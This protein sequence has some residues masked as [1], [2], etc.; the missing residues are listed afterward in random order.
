MKRILLFFVG[1]FFCLSG[2]AQVAEQ[3]P[4]N[5]TA[6]PDTINL[7]SVKT[8]KITRYA[9]G[10]TVD[11]YDFFKTVVPADGTIR[12][13]VTV[14]NISKDNGNP[15]ATAGPDLNFYL[16][17]GTSYKFKTVQNGSP[18]PYG[19]SATDT[20]V[21]YARAADTAFI[22]I[23]LPGGAIREYT[24]SLK[25]ELTDQAPNDAEPNHSMAQALPVLPAEMKA[26]HSGYYG[27]ST[28]SQGGY[29]GGSFDEYDY[30]RIILPTA[31]S[32]RFYLSAYNSSGVTMSTP[33][34]TVLNKNGTSRGIISTNGSWS[35]GPL[36]IGTNESIAYKATVYDTINSYAS[37]AD[38]LYFSI[39]TPG[40]RYSDKCYN[41][42]VKYE[43]LDAGT[44]D[45]EPN[46]NQATATPIA[47][48]ET[49]EGTS[50]YD[51]N[52]DVDLNDYYK[53]LLPADGT[54]RIYAKAIN[55]SGTP[56]AAPVI[57]VTDKNGN[58]L[59]IMN[60]KRNWSN[61]GLTIGGGSDN[62]N[63]G[64]SISDTMSVYSLEADSIYIIVSTPGLRY[65]NKTFNYSF[66][67]EL[68]DQSQ[69][70]TEPNNTLATATMTTAGSIL[71]GHVSYAKVNYQRDVAD[72]YKTVM[73]TNGRIRF[74]VSAKNTN[75]WYDETTPPYLTIYN[76]NGQNIGIQSTS[77]SW[78][79]SAIQIDNAHGNAFYLETVYD[80]LF[81]NCL[82]GDTLYFSIHQTYASFS[83]TIRYE[84]ENNEPSSEFS[85]T[86]TG[87]E[88]GF[89]NQSTNAQQYKWLLGNNNESTVTH[90]FKAYV[91]GYYEVKLISTNT[92]C[93]FKDTVMHPLEI[94]GVEY[95]TP[96][97]AG[98][99]GDLN[100]QIFGG[101]LNP[102]TTLVTLKKGNI[103][104]IPK[105]TYS[106]DKNNRLGLIFDLHNVETGSY[107]VTI[108]VPGQ[109]AITYPGG[110][111]IN[112]LVYP[113][114]WSQVSGPGRWRTNTDT[115]FN[116]VVGNSGN[117]TAHGTIVALLWP[118]SVDLKFEQKEYR[119]STAGTSQVT[120]NDGTYSILNSALDWVYD[121]NTTTPIDT[122]IN[123]AFNGYARYFFV[124]GVEPNSTY[125]IPF[126]VKAGSVANQRFITYTLKPNQFG[127]CP[128]FNI[129]DALTSP[130]AIEFYINEL[131]AAV[132][133]T[134]IVPAKVIVKGLGIS[135]KHIDVSSQIMFHRFWANWY[136]ADDLTE[137]EYYDYYKKEEV[138]NEFAWQK[139]KETAVDLAINRAI[140]SRKADL[141]GDIARYNNNLNNPKIR[142]EMF[143][144]GNGKG[145]VK[146]NGLRDARIDEVLELAKYEKALE[147]VRNVKKID[148]YRKLLE[149]YIKNN[150][151]EHEKQEDYLRDKLNK[152]KDIIDP[153]ET[154]TNSV[155]S[156]DPNAIYGPSGTGANQY[157]NDKNRHPFLITFE[158]AD[159]ASA[160]A[161]IVRIIDTLD[162][163]K[164]DLKTLELGNV[165]IGKK[166]FLVPKGRRE[167][168]ME[169]SLMPEKNMN[170]RINASLDTTKGIITWQF[171]SIDPI[172]KDI[173]ALAGFLPPNTNRPN[174]EGSVSY[175]IQPIANLA[176]GNSMQS[177][178]AIV[179][180]DNTPIITNTWK[181]ILDAQK[182][183]SKA[184]ATVLQDTLI[185]LKM[186][187][188]DL[189]S[190]IGYYNVY[191]SIQDGQWQSLGGTELDTMTVIG[192]PGKTYRFYAVA[193]DKVGNL[194]SKTPAA[195]ASVTLKEGTT[196]PVEP[197]VTSIDS[198]PL[199][200]Y[201]SPTTGAVTVKVK[202]AV[203]EQ[204]V[205]SVYSTTGSKVADVYTGT[206]NGNLNIPVNLSHL[207]NGLY[208]IR[209]RSNAGTQYVQKVMIMK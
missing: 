161:Q 114:T 85:Y 131:D 74:Y 52:F 128:T 105:E 175:T 12:V 148:D 129:M 137:S 72:Y 80:T 103:T 8:G 56:Q 199:K 185:H 165:T 71:K 157:V 130:Q 29:S 60:N 147:G 55:T 179:F 198:L 167:F 6:A 30:Y 22:S 205:I 196:P 84:F 97:T 174:G 59:G 112:G 116:L 183:S 203:A 82:M 23:S 51:V 20:L 49:K 57:T 100:L 189:A 207:S 155:T 47:A 193:Q 86:R 139:M 187:G 34:L 138:A 102:A 163:T 27:G 164:F 96:K 40:I 160:D 17:N 79:N 141:N 168:V 26:G 13:V 91:P 156:F 78:S 46:N 93:N 94:K 92:S 45:P 119:P 208:Y 182:P 143:A 123:G 142:N 136:G 64:A 61:A 188:V 166:T 170:V 42:T 169:K 200:V 87:N 192:E 151:P 144:S 16:E 101:G 180:D 109:A 191:V 154:N 81:S 178:A 177:K 15:V 173:P 83:Y 104:L 99:G 150:C 14:N 184:T 108:Q 149:D 197:P 118:K 70:D 11:Q 66:R 134:K 121:L 95:Y 159:T 65:S 3:E 88:F 127:S 77:G 19:G 120:T 48:G 75:H 39:S 53:T 7:G 44:D 152:E 18:I 122:F 68:E 162:K 146:M 206:V 117:V 132:D 110:L 90:P 36:N 41:Y 67:Y 2:M 25:Y 35:N 98:V 62:I 63:Y 201:P 172:S 124:P 37:G 31:G 43:V 50:G 54:V 9:D 111:V 186:T 73:P 89:L 133:K 1:V 113:E 135:Q 69:N 106:A 76:K 126:T 24:Y 107:D 38:T 181:N 140:D 209:M 115:K 194:E 33:A 125:E 195:E 202:T 171:T 158:N 204:V 4:N 145:I 190:G 32:V 10:P 176:D 58:T 28:S 153:R 21:I 5:S